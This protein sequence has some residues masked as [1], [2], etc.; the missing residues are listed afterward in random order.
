MY[1]PIDIANYF[2]KKYGNESKITPMKLVKLVYIA[3]GWYLGISD[4]A[5]IDENPEAW[6]Y[7]PVIPRVYHHFKDYGREAIT[8][9]NFPN[10]PDDNLPEQIKTFLDKIWEVYG[11]FSAIQLSAKTHEIGTPW[12]ITWSKLVQQNNM[13]RKTGFGVFSNKSVRN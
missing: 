3:H 2:L 1:N 12:Y 8:I 11:K 6:K 5:L 13:K 7:G 4:K 9:N 10:N